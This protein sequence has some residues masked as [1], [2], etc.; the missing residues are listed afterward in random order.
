MKL[1]TMFEL[2]DAIILIFILK[3]LCGLKEEPGGASGYFF[4][5]LAKT[6]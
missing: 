5:I 1:N 6:T 3:G 2:V 4:I